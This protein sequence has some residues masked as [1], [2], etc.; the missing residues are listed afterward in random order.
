MS[1]LKFELDRDRTGTPNQ[2]FLKTEADILSVFT[3]RLGNY[4]F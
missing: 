2:N 3:Q 1:Y 4:I